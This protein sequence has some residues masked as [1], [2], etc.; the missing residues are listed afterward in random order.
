MHVHVIKSVLFICRFFT[1]FF[2]NI[3][4]SQKDN[5]KKLLIENAGSGKYKNYCTTYKNTAKL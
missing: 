1:N 5:V 4:G 2:P 3:V